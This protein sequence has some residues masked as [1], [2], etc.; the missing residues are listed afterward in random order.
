MQE[1]ER[2]LVYGLYTYFY[3][4]IYGY[5]IGNAPQDRQQ[6]MITNLGKR[7]SKY[8]EI[9][10]LGF[11]FFFE[12]IMFQWEYWL[13]K[14]TKRKIALEWLIGKKAIQRWMDRNEHSAYFVNENIVKAY[15]IDRDGLRNKYYPGQE[16]ADDA[17]ELEK[18][19]HQG[20]ARLYHC[21]QFTTMYNH[22]SQVCLSCDMKK[23]CKKLLQEIRPEIYKKRFDVKAE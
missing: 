19:R 12:Y 23:D 20:A 6:A 16:N 17:E 9:S 5:S 7:L 4:K 15:G 1:E 11:D 3:Q 8:Y 2:R 10:S 14:R 22:R 21:S 18:T 13:D